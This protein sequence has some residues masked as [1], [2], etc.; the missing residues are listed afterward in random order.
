M[1]CDL[2]EAT[3]LQRLDVKLPGQPV[4]GT[5]PQLR[6]VQ[7]GLLQFVPQ[8]LPEAIPVVSSCRA[9]RR[10]LL[11]RQNL[12][13]ASLYLWIFAGDVVGAQ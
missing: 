9:K 3:R 13:V 11:L 8:A 10:L 5:F 7:I 12:P 1:N 4:V 2:L 6:F